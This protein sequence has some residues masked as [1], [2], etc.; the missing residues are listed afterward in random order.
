M[1]CVVALLAI[2]SLPCPNLVADDRMEVGSPQA[3]ELFEKHIRPIFAQHC[4]ACHG[5]K[6]QESALRLDSRAALLEGGLNGPTIVAGVPEESRLIQA[7]GYKDESLK[8][9]P[10][11]P[12]PKEAVAN[13]TA[14]VRSGAP[15][16]NDNSRRQGGRSL[17]DAWRSHWAAQPVSKKPPPTVQQSPWATSPIDHFVLSKLESEGLSPSPPADRQRLLRRA[18]FDLLGLPPTLEETASFEGDKSPDAF[19][20]VIERLLASP[21]YGERWGRHW[22]DVA[23]YAD[24]KEYVRLSE[25]RRLLYAYAYRDYVIRAFNE[26]MPYNQFVIEQL[27]ADLLSPAASRSSMAALGFLSL[28]RQFTANPHDIID[29]RIDVTTRGLLGLTVTCARCHNHKYDAI[30]TDDYYSLYGVFASSEVPQVPYLIDMAPTDPTRQ[31]HLREAERRET[32]FNRFQQRAHKDLT[33]ELRSKVGAYLLGTLDGRRSFL[34]PMPSAPDEVRNF[35]VERWLDYL[36]YSG[37]RESPAFVPW[38]ALAR[39]K[40]DGNFATNAA[41]IL[42]ELRSANAASTTPRCN[43]VVLDAIERR[44]PASLSDVARAYTDVFNS[45]YSQWKRARHQRGNLLTNASF[46]DVDAPAAR[47]LAGW[48]LVGIGFCVSANKG[49]SEGQMAAV[50]ATSQGAPSEAATFSQVVATRPGCSYRLSFA[51]A[52]TSNES[53]TRTLLVRAVGAKPCLEKSTDVES[54]PRTMFEDIELDFV[55]DGPSTT[56]SFTDGPT[57][58]GSPSADMIVDD[59]RLVETSTVPHVAAE[60]PAGE[61]DHSDEAELASILVDAKSPT[62]FTYFEGMEHYLYESK[63]HDRIGHLRGQLY[64]WL[65]AT[66]RAPLRAH[67]L[68]ERLVVSEPCVFLRGDPTRHGA[69]VPLR[70]LELLATEDRPTFRAGVGRLDLAKAIV[71]P[72]NPLT[73]RVLVNRVWAHHFGAGLVRTTSNFGLRGE[74]PS[75]SDLLDYLAQRFV[76]EGWSI[77]QLH[78]LIML[79]STYQQASS[80]RADAFSRD[81][82]NRLLWRMSRQRLDVE[83]MRDA[84]VV[85]TGHLDETVGGPPVDINAVGCR[86]RTVYGFVDR[87]GLAGV[88]RTFDF[89]SPEAHSPTRFTTTVPQQALFLLNG[90][91]ILVQS[92]EVAHRAAA[93]HVADDILARAAQMWRIVLGRPPNDHESA[94]MKG[95][96]DLGGTWDELAQVLLL[97]NE[98]AFVD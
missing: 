20:K 62:A 46:E 11:G 39:V 67:V 68:A 84:M 16:P 5:Q 6:K 53:R 58:G 13:I 24:T 82:E 17:A 92:R 57:A 37:H 44:G 10:D 54:W 35:F 22:L 9:P 88:L 12:L 43:G 95:F 28:G 81:P 30:P 69:T 70:F 7:I 38:G 96:I 21:H 93:I 32:A 15:W 19:R 48:N 89:A 8:M 23:R 65:S 36:E 91:F 90:P 83:A 49:A 1:A 59:I 18:S 79:S 64:E 31:E 71:D 72:A 2:L 61:R 45:A 50:L 51:V 34:V 55:A 80:Y 47:S 78:R 41:R 14:W 74:A 94:A 27:A 60:S 73:A 52:V 85:A 26:D 4:L 97:S 63:V 98:F 3:V 76:A 40:N 42:A 75:H 86:R 77:K 87:A 29:D 56:I 66:D 33:D 25:E